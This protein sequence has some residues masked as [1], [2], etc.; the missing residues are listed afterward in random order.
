MKYEVEPQFLIVEIVSDHGGRLGHPVDPDAEMMI[1]STGFWVMREI[2]F[3]K[4]IDDVG[5]LDNDCRAELCQPLGQERRELPH[6]G[7]RSTDRPL[8]GVAELRER[9]S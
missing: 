9:R 2:V 3:D 4:S 5:L 1:K 6:E 7:L 8:F